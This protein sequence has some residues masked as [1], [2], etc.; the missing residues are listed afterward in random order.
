MKKRK[1]GRYAVQIYLGR[2]EGVRKYHTVYGKTQK[3]ARDK[4]AEL[5]L[6]QGKG[7]DI[8]AAGDAFGLWAQ[9]FLA[10]KKAEGVSVSHY[11]NLERF[12]RHL[13]A[14]NDKPIAKI[15]S[16]DIQDIINYLAGVHDGKMPM[17]KRTLNGVKQAAG[18]VFRLAMVSRVI[19][20]NPADYVKVP[21]TAAARTRQAIPE[22]QQRWIEEMPHRAQTAAMIMLHAGLRMGEVTAL[23]WADIDLNAAEIRVNKSAQFTS[24]QPVIKGTKTAAGDRVV[25]I[26]AVL[27]KHLQEARANDDCL[28]VVHSAG[29]KMLS[30]IGWKRLWDSYMRDLNL[31]YGF[32]PEARRML[33]LA[34]DASLSKFAPGGLP[35]LIETFDRHQLRHTFATNCYL[36]GVD[37]AT[38]MQWMGHTDIKTTLSI[39]T[40]LDK[41][42]KRKKLGIM[43]EFNEWKRQRNLSDTSHEA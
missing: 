6:R 37:A 41:K 38:C 25:D 17:A 33:G 35:M 20:Y 2:V 29:G 24:G 28:Y 5:R 14:L 7:I 30:K 21:K 11:G 4:A 40:H 10:Q 36:A 27:V 34:P 42:Y 1:D 8:S 19:D 31:R 26:P 12:C 15:T 23:T 18:Q 13:A 43:N 22:Q 9:R 39:Y 16:A 3:E 32:T